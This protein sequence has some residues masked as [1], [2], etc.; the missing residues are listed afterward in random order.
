MKQF[1]W[2]SAFVVCTITASNAQSTLTNELIWASGEFS[3]EGIDGLRSMKDGMHYSGLEDS[4]AFGTKIVRYHYE[5]EKDVVTLATAMDIFGN[6][7]TG[8]ED[9]EFSA[10]EKKILIQTVSEQIYRHSFLA[11]Y[12]IYNTETKST[13]P[14]ADFKLGKQRLATFNPQGTMVAFVRDNNVYVYDLAKR[15]ETQVTQDGEF[16][17]IINGSTD[18]VYEEEFALVNG[19]SWSAAGDRLAYYKFNESAVREFSMDMFGDLYPT[20]NR[21]KYPKAGETNSEVSIWV[22][23]LTTRENKQVNTGTEKDQYI[24]RIK[25]TQDNNKLVVLRMNRH[26]NHLEL[27]MT[28]LTLNTPYVIETKVAFQEKAETYIDVNDALTYLKDGSFIWMSEMDNYNHIYHMNADGTVR[29]QLTKGR[30]DVIDFY[31]YGFDQPQGGWSR[32]V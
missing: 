4:D 26:Q 30:Y 15:T 28:D 1:F 19:M 32:D 27:L 12:Y 6:V 23:D 8:I 13:V 24:P 9:Y 20:Q 3:S 7:S 29:A 10:D 25:W 21:F 5:D 2:M 18:W 16:N 31:G 17:K 11:N 14:L 22:Y